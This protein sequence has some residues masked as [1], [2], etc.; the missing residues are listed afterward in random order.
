MV[1]SK[2]KLIVEQRAESDK[3]Q[4]ARRKTYHILIDISKQI[5]II[6]RRIFYENISHT[7]L[8]IK[9]T[10]WTLIAVPN[11]NYLS[12]LKLI[13]LHIVKHRWSNEKQEYISTRSIEISPDN[14][15]TSTDSSTLKWKRAILLRRFWRSGREWTIKRGDNFRKTIGRRELRRIMMGN[16]QRERM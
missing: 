1:I 2:E 14:S 3:Q 12:C 13:L 11:I 9:V 5:V 8:L 15:S 4:S 16:P 7:S 10:C 6:V